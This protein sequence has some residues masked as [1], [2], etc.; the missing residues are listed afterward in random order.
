MMPDEKSRFTARIAA[1]DAV[2]LRGII[3]RLES[4]PESPDVLELLDLADDNLMSLMG[5]EGDW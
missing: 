3:K 5:G 1:A 2:G 4:L